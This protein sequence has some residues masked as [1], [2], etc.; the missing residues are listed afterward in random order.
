M[1]SAVKT[2][3]KAVGE[4]VGGGRPGVLR[5]FAAAAVVGAASAVLTYK[6]LRK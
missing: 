3:G 4:R 6:A 2:V 5:A 1:S